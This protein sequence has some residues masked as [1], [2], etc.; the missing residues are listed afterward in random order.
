MYLLTFRSFRSSSSDVL[1]V[2][3]AVFPSKVIHFPGKLRVD[4]YTET[5]NVQRS[6]STKIAAWHPGDPGT[7]MKLY[8]GPGAYLGVHF[9]IFELYTKF[10]VAWYQKREFFYRNGW[11]S[12]SGS[13]IRTSSVCM[14]Y[15]IKLSIIIMLHH[16]LPVDD[17]KSIYT[18]TKR[19]N[20]LHV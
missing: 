11:F 14:Y 20:V 9:Y 7:F 5:L 1:S 19:R 16:S 6:V 18:C 2:K 3:T 4:A 17:R 10:R 13:H 12:H 15:N 8:L